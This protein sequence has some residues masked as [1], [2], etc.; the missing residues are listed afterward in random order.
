MYHSAMRCAVF[1]GNTSAAHALLER[2]A[3]VDDDIFLLAVEVERE[4]VIPLLLQRGVDINAQNKEGTALQLA[5]Q[6]TTKAPPKLFF[7]IP[8]SISRREVGMTEE[9]RCFGLSELGTRRSYA[10]SSIRVQISTSHLVMDLTA[11]LVP[12]RGKTRTWSCCFS[13]EVPM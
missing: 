8:R 9:L 1:C 12:L 11:F 7:R 13:I 3:E 10:C 4:T 5:M 6:I 2:G